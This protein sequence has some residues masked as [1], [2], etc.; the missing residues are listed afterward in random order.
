MAGQVAGYLIWGKERERLVTKEPEYLFQQQAIQ[1]IPRPLGLEAQ[2]MWVL[3]EVL[4]NR[5]GW[6][7]GK[8]MPVF[9]EG[10]QVVGL[11]WLQLNKGGQRYVQDKASSFLKPLLK[12]PSSCAF[13]NSLTLT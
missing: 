7:V 1:E 9:Q 13:T 5:Q 12:A 3:G 2:L 8:K 11:M 6:L 4:M 10:L